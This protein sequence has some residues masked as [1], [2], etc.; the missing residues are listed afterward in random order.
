MDRVL[1]SQSGVLTT[2]VSFHYENYVRAARPRTEE[3]QEVYIVWAALSSLARHFQ[4]C[5]SWRFKTPPKSLCKR[6]GHRVWRSRNIHS[7]CRSIE[8]PYVDNKTEGLIGNVFCCKTPVALLFLCRKCFDS[9]HA[10]KALFSSRTSCCQRV[11]S[12]FGDGSHI[13]A[14]RHH[15][16][17]CNPTPDC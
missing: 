12:L 14:T 1:R 5:R 16:I 11:L 6:S 8:L 9:V 17:S 15:S 4:A 10:A 7:S 3:S 13:A 2:A